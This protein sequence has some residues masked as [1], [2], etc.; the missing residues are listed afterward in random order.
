MQPERFA[1]HFQVPPVTH[2]PAPELAI[3]GKFWSAVRPVNVPDARTQR[4]Q[5][6]YQRFERLADT[7]QRSG[8]LLHQ[9]QLDASLTLRGLAATHTMILPYDRGH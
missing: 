9:L 7:A 6:L 4:L 2:G 1:L 3:L 5:L 8:A